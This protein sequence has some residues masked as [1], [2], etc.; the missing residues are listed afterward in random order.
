MRELPA[1][2]PSNMLA[3]HSDI[4]ASDVTRPNETELSYRWR[5]RVWME[6]NVVA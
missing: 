6:M 5:E 2:S 4:E 1:H 3:Q